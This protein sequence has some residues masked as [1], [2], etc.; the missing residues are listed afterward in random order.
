MQLF[1]LSVFDI[2]RVIKIVCL[3]EAVD[4]YSG[5]RPIKSVFLGDTGSIFTTGF[6]KNGMRELALWDSVSLF[7][8]LFIPYLSK[9]N[10]LKFC[11]LTLLTK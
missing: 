4:V 11:T 10:V 7:F 2:M 3:Q 1:V 5:S 9:V 6:S 8:K